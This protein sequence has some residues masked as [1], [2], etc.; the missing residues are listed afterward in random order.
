MKN[1]DARLI[2]NIAW[3]IGGENCADDVADEEYAIRIIKMVRDHDKRLTKRS[4]DRAKSAVK[5]SSSVAP[6]KSTRRGR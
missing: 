3:W 2:R 5:K 4:P 6:R 1:K